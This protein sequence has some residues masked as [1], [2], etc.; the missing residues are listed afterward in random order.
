MTV[1]MSNFCRLLTAASLLLAAEL[2]YDGDIWPFSRPAVL[3]PLIWW[4]IYLINRRRVAAPVLGLIDAAAHRAGFQPVPG[5]GSS[6][7]R[8]SAS[9][10]VPLNQPA[11]ATA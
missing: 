4:T 7:P 5:H 2:L 6:K 8:A 3:I 10:A 1:A 11:A 9:A